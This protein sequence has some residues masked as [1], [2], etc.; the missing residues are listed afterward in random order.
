MLW[1]CC[2]SISLSLI[3]T[4][5]SSEALA[6][7]SLVEIKNKVTEF[8]L[9]KQR[10]QAVQVIDQALTLEKLNNAQKDE[11]ISIKCHLLTL[12]LT[13]KAQASYENG[14]KFLY[15]NKRNSLKSIQECLEIEPDNL[16]CRWLELRWK[17]LYDVND[18]D[19]KAQQY[20]NATEGLLLFHEQHEQI[21]Y[22]LGIKTENQNEIL[23]LKEYL[24][25]KSVS[26]AQVSLLEIEN[27]YPDYPDLIIYKAKLD[28]SA[29]VAA[30]YLAKINELYQKRCQEMTVETVRKYLYD[31]NLCRSSLND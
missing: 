30:V 24:K 15:N 8:V 28:S 9:L 5:I 13:D 3:V 31:F 16:S 10:A 11:L 26:E 1:R 27:K 21:K 12:F 6:L 23:K 19:N 20:I 7:K 22:Q 14:I 2:F 29:Q 25:S 18:F 4:F 17:K